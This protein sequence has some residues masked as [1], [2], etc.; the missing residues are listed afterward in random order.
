M[1]WLLNFLKGFTSYDLV[2]LLV[3]LAA[4]GLYIWV[5]FIY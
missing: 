2:L 5:V 3:S 1:S 4:T